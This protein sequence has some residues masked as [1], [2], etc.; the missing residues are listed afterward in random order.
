MKVCIN[1]QLFGHASVGH[2]SAGI[3]VITFLSFYFSLFSHLNIFCL[4]LCTFDGNINDCVWCPL[5]CGALA[6]T[7]LLLLEILVL[8]R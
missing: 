8:L 3:K 7:L 6:C 5:F 4:E 2:N 1:A